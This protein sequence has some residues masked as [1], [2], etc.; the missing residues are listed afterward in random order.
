MVTSVAFSSGAPLTKLFETWRNHYPLRKLPIELSRPTIPGSKVPDNIINNNSSR[1]LECLFLGLSVGC[2]S[3][4]C[5]MQF[6]V[7]IVSLF[8]AETLVVHVCHVIIVT[9]PSSSEC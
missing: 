9:C 6:A 5:S 3:K 4:T 1:I 7:A 8:S 2:G